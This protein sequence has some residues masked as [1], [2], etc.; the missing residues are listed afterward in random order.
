M[1]SDKLKYVVDEYGNIAIFSP[2]ATHAD[3]ARAMHGKPVGAGFITVDI[4]ISGHDAGDLDINC[5]GESVSLNIK[6][7]QVTDEI[8]ISKKLKGY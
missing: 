5:F 7:R 8:I 2:G 4:Q 6:S 1:Y 3:I